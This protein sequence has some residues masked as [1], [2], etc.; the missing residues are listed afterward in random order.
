MLVLNMLCF[1]ISALIPKGT[2]YEGAL[3]WVFPFPIRESS[4]LHHPRWHDGFALPMP[5]Q[6]RG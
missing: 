2:T 1:N 6:F 3:G 5:G 4:N